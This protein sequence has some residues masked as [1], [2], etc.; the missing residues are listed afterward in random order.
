MTMKTVLVA[1]A[2]GVAGLAALEHFAGLDGWEVLA[3]SRRRPDAPAGRWRHLPLDLTDA[4]ACQAAAPQLAKVTHLVYGALFE[5]PGLV[6]GW[7]DREQMQINL[8]ML[9]NLMRPLMA[10]AKDLAH[11]SLLQGGK[12]YG[13]HLHPIPLP[14]KERWPRDPH[15]NFYWLQEDYLREAA[16]RAGWA[17]T[18]FRPQVIFGGATGAAMNLIPVLGAYAALRREEGEPFSYPGGAPS[19]LEAVDARLLARAFAWAAEAPAARNETFNLTNGDVFVWQDIWPALADMLGVDTGPATSFSVA[20]YMAA[21]TE[22]W[23]RIVARERLKPI[24]LL[25]LVGQSHHYADILFTYGRPT[26]RQ[27]LI[28]STIK[29]RQAGFADCIDT[30]DMFRDWFQ[31]MRNRRILP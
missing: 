1:G 12:A 30:E 27:P 22:T 3:V 15:E 29:I 19:I 31:V 23:S 16:A 9:D 28:V 4:A 18:I 8:A 25:D 5:K 24:P 20:D 6:A 7:R 26:P 11:V 17:L 14:A 10:S 13:M 21:R 2:T